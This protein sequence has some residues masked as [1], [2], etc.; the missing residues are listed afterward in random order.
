VVGFPLSATVFVV[1]QR[2]I[3]HYGANLDRISD[4][5]TAL[6]YA[7]AVL[8]FGVIVMMMFCICARQLL[9]SGDC[10]FTFLSHEVIIND[11]KLVFR[12]P[13]SVDR[14]TVANAP[15]VLREHNPILTT[16]DHDGAADKIELHSLLSLLTLYTLGFITWSWPSMISAAASEKSPAQHLAAGVVTLLTVLAALAPFA[17]TWKYYKRS[18]LKVQEANGRA[19]EGTAMKQM[20]KEDEENAL[21]DPHDL[22]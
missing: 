12:V 17:T 6:R 1:I 9:S 21:L 2:A 8:L 16:D 20:H 5:E 14:E 4:D 15:V 11:E 22:A 10:C 3:A 13:S 19:R 7:I 18:Q